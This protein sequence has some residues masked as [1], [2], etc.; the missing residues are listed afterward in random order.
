M[1]WCAGFGRLGGVGG[2]L[3]G[4]LLIGAGLTLNSIF[5]VLA[6]LAVL[7]VVLTLLVPRAQGPR[8]LH[9]TPI[10][11]SVTRAE[12]ADHPSPV[13]LDGNGTSVAVTE[14]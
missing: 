12:A 9:S 13:A 2:P 6:G 14:A 3:I 4:G 11:P 1:A 5:Y 10:E 8:E 7:G